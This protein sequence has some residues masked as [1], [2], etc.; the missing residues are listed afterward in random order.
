ML[1]ERE[2]SFTKKPLPENS[3]SPS[4]ILLFLP[5]FFTFFLGIF[6][7]HILEITQ[8]LRTLPAFSKDSDSVPWI[9]MAA[10]SLGDLISS[11][12]SV[13]IVY[14]FYIKTKC[15]AMLTLSLSHKQMFVVQ[16]NG[17]NAIFLYRYIYDVLP[18]FHSPLA[19]VFLLVPHNSPSCS[20]LFQLTIY[21]KDHVI[22]IYLLFCV[23][24]S[25]ACWWA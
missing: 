11:L 12:A 8:R 6:H 3:L 4:F 2:C 5:L 9:H 13:N 21:E 17:F 24:I 23:Y 19:L 14:V 10:H 1:D 20:V 15:R 16:I 25:F 7:L 18:L 22:L